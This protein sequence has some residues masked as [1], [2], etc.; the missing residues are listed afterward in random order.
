MVFRKLRSL[1]GA[2]KRSLFQV[3]Y[4]SWCRLK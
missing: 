3:F 2:S 1:G 4:S